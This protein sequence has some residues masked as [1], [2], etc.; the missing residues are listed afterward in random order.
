MN[1]DNTLVLFDDSEI[2]E[3]QVTFK[4]TR[5]RSKYE[6]YGTYRKDKLLQQRFSLTCELP[7]KVYTRFGECVVI[8]DEDTLRQWLSQESV[9]TPLAIDLETYG[10]WLDSC[11]VMGS[12]LDILT[13]GVAVT[14]LSFGYN[15]NAVCVH[16]DTGLDVKRTFELVKDYPL[17]VFN[18]GFDIG[19]I[20]RVLDELPNLLSDIQVAYGMVTAGLRP[21]FQKEISLNQLAMHYLNLELSKSVRSKFV[22]ASVVDDEFIRYSAEDAA[23][24]IICYYKLDEDLKQLGLRDLFYGLEMKVLPVVILMTLHG[25]DIDINR[26]Y[27]IKDLLQTQA[28]KIADDLIKMKPD[29]IRNPTSRHDIMLALRSEG[30]KVT[31]INK[32]TLRKHQ[33][34]LFVQRF[35]EWRKVQTLF[36]SQFR[37]WVEKHLHP[38]TKRLHPSFT[39]TH[40]DTGRL[41]SRNPNGQ[42]IAKE[43]GSGYLEGVDVRECFIAPDGSLLV[44]ADYSQY[45]LRILAE[46]S[47]D[48]QMIQEYL[49][50]YEYL[51]QF[52][53]R[54]HQLGVRSWIHEELDQ[55]LERDE[56][57]Q[58]IQRAL[59]LADKHRRTASLLFNKQPDQITDSERSQA[60]A[61]SFG[62]VYGMGPNSLAELLT[63]TLKQ[64]VSVDDA[65]ELLSNF[66]KGYPGVLQYIRSTERQVK[67]HRY[68]ETM[69]GRKRFFHPYLFLES[70][71]S[72]T[73]QFADLRAGVNARIQGTNADVIKVSLIEMDKLFRGDY[74]NRYPILTV[75]DEIVVVTPKEKADETAQLVRRCM[76]SASERVL[77]TVPTVVSLTVSQ[78]WQK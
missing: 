58:R 22:E 39:L 6:S 77:K 54:L 7:E 35:L 76:V 57:L 72:K 47:Q 67:E 48:R 5:G 66:F 16:L 62:V 9:D 53:E 70:D 28:Q 40:T 68:T 78:H 69:M 8:R 14:A 65:K 26:I 31:N 13:C 18:A 29:I 55:A 4:P 32:N 12:G 34:N 11:N 17:V 60:K 52:E 42:N 59:K 73:A 51:Q 10:V 50:E 1:E 37:P 3:S 44:T 19:I 61:V 43:K 25:L 64:K 74:P 46:I 45:E 63:L 24:T 23:A 33:S 21:P 20:T 38:I 71:V 41:S 49:E 75:H 56:K 2:D 27:Q 36:T 15:Q 30:I